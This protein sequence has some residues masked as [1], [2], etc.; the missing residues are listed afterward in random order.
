MD[1]VMTS[2]YRLS[3]V[4]MSAVVQRNYLGWGVQEVYVISEVM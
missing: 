4:V 3:V 1:R 2:F